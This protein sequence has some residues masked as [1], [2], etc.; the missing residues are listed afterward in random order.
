MSGLGTRMRI[1]SDDEIVA[2]LRDKPHMRI[3]FMEA[4]LT[5]T[6]DALEGALKFLPDP[7]GPAAKYLRP[8]LEA[9]RRAL[10][11]AA[12]ADGR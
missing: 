3:G 8:Q 12:K 5:A 7:N 11:L 6:A 1:P 10:A 9:A 2:D 4:H